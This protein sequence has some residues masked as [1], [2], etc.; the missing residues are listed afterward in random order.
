MSIRANEQ[1]LFTGDI[2]DRK[3]MQRMADI[4]QR[5]TF[6]PKGRLDDFQPSTIRMSEFGKDYYST[7]RE[8][9][10]NLIRGVMTGQGLRHCF[11]RASQLITVRHRQSPGELLGAALCSVGPYYDFES[12]ITGSNDIPSHAWYISAFGSRLN[13]AGH[14]DEYVLRQIARQAT[15]SMSEVM[16]TLYAIHGTYD[17][18]A[19]PSALCLDANYVAE[20][21][22]ISDG[23]HHRMQQLMESLRIISVHPA[24]Q[25][26][27]F[28]DAIAPLD[29]IVTHLKA[30]H[31]TNDFVKSLCE[32]RPIAQ[33]LNYQS[34]SMGGDESMYRNMKRVASATR[35]FL[36]SVLRGLDTGFLRLTAKNLA[37]NPVMESSEDQ[38]GDIS[39]LAD[40]KSGFPV[41]TMHMTLAD[42]TPEPIIRFGESYREQEYVPALLGKLWQK[43]I[44]GKWWQS[45]V[46]AP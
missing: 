10:E 40:T 31:S 14:V 23:I 37:K 27:G 41:A 3:V 46:A 8:E 20:P 34:V 30:E 28:P 38:M 13:I 29:E 11:G 5:P 9:V 6:T 19:F 17:S 24:K 26:T 25:G 16:E 18:D 33:T 45:E 43:V 35:M 32:S 21:T 2:D 1:N 36:E 15:E 39:V 4:V 44:T 7:T 22:V 12:M 42:D